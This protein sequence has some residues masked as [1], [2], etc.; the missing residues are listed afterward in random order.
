MSRGRHRRVVAPATRLGESQEGDLTPSDP[1]P[2]PVR[3]PAAPAPAR[4]P[5]DRATGPAL[6][7]RAA[8]DTD[9]AWGELP[10]AA[11]DARYLREK[12]PHW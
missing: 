7:D 2:R 4:S 3:P 6:P 12:P 10:D 11:D 1:V 5:V 9:A 8:E